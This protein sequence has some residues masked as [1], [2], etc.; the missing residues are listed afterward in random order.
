[1]VS[2]TMTEPVS[3]LIVLPWSVRAVESSFVGAAGCFGSAGFR[4]GSSFLC[5]S[6]RRVSSSSVRAAHCFA[7]VIIGTRLAPLPAEDCR[8]LCGRSSVAVGRLEV[9]LRRH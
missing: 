6:F 3:V 4:L 5:S 1:M 7:W 9:S 2:L 8:N